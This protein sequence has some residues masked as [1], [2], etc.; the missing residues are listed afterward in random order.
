MNLSRYL[1]VSQAPDYA[2]FERRLVAFANDMDFGIVSAALVVERPGRQATC[3]GIGNTPMG[4]EDA[5]KRPEDVARDPVIKL[6]KTTNLPFLYDQD[7]YV[8]NRAGDLWEAQAPFGYGTG[9]SVALHLPGAKHFLLGV[10]RRNE[11]P[12]DGLALTRMFADL[13]LLAVH[14]Q[15]AA[16]RIL[17]SNAGE[18]D[19]P[20]L[21]AREKEVLRWTMEGKSSWAA[22]Q[23]MC[24]AEATIN[25]HVRNALRK[26][27]CSTKLQA[28][29]KA[30]ALGLL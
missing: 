26:L 16:L 25:Y 17:V 12:S 10:D 13:Q 4:F 8:K 5:A 2:S 30:Q 14:A 22:G 11:L 19:I 1:D 24:L 7:L 28:A 18:N 6:M 27:R 21:T 3:I 15:D 23:I 20:T 29:L 9:I